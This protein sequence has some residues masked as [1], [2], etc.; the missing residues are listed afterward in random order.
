MIVYIYLRDFLPYKPFHNYYT[1][2]T[3]SAFCTQLNAFY[4]QSAV[5]IFTQSEF[6]R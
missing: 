6:Y 5:C 2:Y 1:I 4:S 3:W